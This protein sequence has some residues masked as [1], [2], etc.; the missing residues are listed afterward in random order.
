MK[1]L[2][3]ILILS[4][5]ISI[6]GCDDDDTQYQTTGSIEFEF[7]HHWNNDVVTS[8]DFNIIKFENAHGE[9]MSIVKLRYLISNIIL[10]KSDG[11]ELTIDG[12][13][14]IDLTNNE[15]STFVQGIPFDNYSGI[16]FIF[17]FNE[18]DN[19]DGA[20]NDLNATSWNWPSMLGGGYHFMQFE[21]KYSDNGLESPFAYHMGTAKVS[22]GVFEQNFFSVNLG[23]F[24]FSKDSTLD[25][26]MNIAEWFVNP[27]E[28]D[29]NTYNVNLM[30][31]YNAQKL[32]QQNGQSV[33]SLGGIN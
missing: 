33:F 6:F 14:L 24:S 7:T 17:G 12:Y 20:Y 13:Y 15:T 25:L 28:W 2:K 22:D 29:L 10:H 4:I 1:I 27:Y 8:N 21:G 18:S 11:T 23:G 9:L 32:M 31:N 16:S 26:K 30:P 3:Y 19:I 5:V